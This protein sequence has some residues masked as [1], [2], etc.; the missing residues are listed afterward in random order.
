[1]I[2]AINLSVKIGSRQILK[3]INFTFQDKEK[4]A[5]VGPNGSGKTTLLRAL[6]GML[7]YMGEIILDGMEIRKYKRQDIA[8][9]VSYVP[10]IFYTPYTFTVEEFVKMGKYVDIRNWWNAEEIDRYLDDVGILSLKARYVNTLSGGELQKVLIARALAQNPKIIML[11]EPTSHL[12]PKAALEIN[13]I[14]T[15]LD[16]TVISV[17]HDLNA[18]YNLYSK[19]MVM[20]NGEIFGIFEGRSQD[21][22]DAISKIYGIQYEIMGNRFIVPRGP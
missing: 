8:K 10:Q 13:K 21:F 12:D 9:L 3:K 15:N 20:A 16:K 14:I 17:V 5:I 7:P 1:M 11:D 19:I 6:G 2:E 22:V 4:I 18:A